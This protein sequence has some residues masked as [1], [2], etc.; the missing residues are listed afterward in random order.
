MKETSMSSERKF[1]V[2]KFAGKYAHRTIKGGM[3]HNLA[4]E[5]P[6]AFAKAVLEVAYDS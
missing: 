2:K 3:G 1:A 6:N 4:H 5:A